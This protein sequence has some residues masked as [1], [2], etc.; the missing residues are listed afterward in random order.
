MNED[1]ITKLA[2]ALLA[3][4]ADALRSLCDDLSAD[5]KRVKLD[6]EALVALH[7]PKP[8]EDQRDE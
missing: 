4:L 7:Q 2:D 6:I 5:H 8:K 3:K 1:E